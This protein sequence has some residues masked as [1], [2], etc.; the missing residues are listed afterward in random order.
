MSQ[1]NIKWWS[2]GYAVIFLLLSIRFVV[3]NFESSYPIWYIILSSICYLLT[4][5]G[6]FSYALSI[7]VE[8]LRRPWRFVAICIVLNF[9]ASGIIDQRF[10][11]YAGRT[12]FLTDVLI[13][14]VGIALFYPA[15]RANFLLAN[16]WPF[17]QQPSN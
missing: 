1:K 13:W 17:K 2:L 3:S 16:L 10:G 5:I 4:N 14:G 11:E 6:N 8:S 12:N 15:F 7:A 9:I